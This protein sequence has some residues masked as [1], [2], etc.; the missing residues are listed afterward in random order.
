MPTVIPFGTRL[1]A[2]L[3]A[4]SKSQNWLAKKTDIDT[5]TISR[6][7]TGKATPTVD[8][9]AQF[10]AAL[11]IAPGELVDGTNIADMENVEDAAEASAQARAIEELNQKVAELEAELAGERERHQ[12]VEAQKSKEIE[13]LK[14]EI[15]TVES[16]HATASEMAAQNFKRFSDAMGLLERER[17]LRKAAEKRAE[18]ADKAMKAAVGVGIFT[19]L[20]GAGLGYVA[21]DSEGK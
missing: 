14:G 21:R 12:V 20:A 6:I 15:K 13:R 16:L 3:D 1:R 10:A 17:K 19:T 7:V 2:L 4:A 9:L 11:K 18:A 5:A 8:H